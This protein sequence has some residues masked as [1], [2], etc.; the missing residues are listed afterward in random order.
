[1]K[2]KDISPENR[3][4]ERLLNK[5][6]ESLSKAEL[7]AIILKTGTRE[8][9]VIDLSNYIL[10]NFS[11]SSLQK[12][13]V[14][15]LKL[16]KGI[17]NSKAAQIKAIFELNKRFQSHKINYKEI[18][19]PKQI[20]EYIKYDLKYKT[21]EHLLAIYLRKNKIISKKLINIG[22]SDQTLISHKEIISGAIRENAQGI[23][24]AHNHPSGDPNP[25]REDILAT[26][27]LQKIARDLEMSLLDHIIISKNN[28]FSF[29][30]K[31]II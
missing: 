8:K 4:L 12:S 17:G 30:E 22:T 19:N 16:I 10:S 11:Y 6:P 5:G 13:S 18:Y 15:E 25:S 24:I 31:G 1:M 27:K 28:Y 26:K 21:Q 14:N 3:P 20:Y 29:K 7:L 23:I 2:L 9:N